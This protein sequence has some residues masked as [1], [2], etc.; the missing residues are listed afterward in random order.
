MPA[1]AKSLDNCNKDTVDECSDIL[2]NYPLFDT[3][4]KKAANYVPVL[5][6]RA[7]YNSKIYREKRKARILRKYFIKDL[8]GKFS[9]AYQVTD[10][11]LQVKAKGLLG[12]EIIAK[13]KI[14]EFDF[15]Y[16]NRV[17]FSLAKTAKM[18]VEANIG[19]I[20]LLNLHIKSNANKKTNE[21]L[22]RFL[23]KEVN[24]LTEWRTTS[25]KLAELPYTMYVEGTSEDKKDFSAKSKGYIGTSEI[26]GDIKMLE[27]DH[28]IAEEHYG[29]VLI[30]TDI[31]V[32]D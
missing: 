24:Y 32:Y 22:G 19:G 17:R 15:D 27:K 7:I 5:P 18:D 2:A 31:S 4:Y 26:F 1:Y 21:V 9:E 8:S 28:Y 23:G 30:K 16:Y 12:R 10:I 6:L 20:P 14:N 13:G 11:N 3:E 29:P 25:G